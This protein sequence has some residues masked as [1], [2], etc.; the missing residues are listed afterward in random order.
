MEPMCQQFGW[1]CHESRVNFT[2]YR[3]EQSWISLWFARNIRLTCMGSKRLFECISKWV[4]PSCISHVQ[5]MK[6]DWL[7]RCRRKSSARVN[8]EPS[9]SLSSSGRALYKETGHFL[10]PCSWGSAHF[11]P[12]WPFLTT[13][14]FCN[15]S[16]PSAPGV[17]GKKGGF[18]WA[19]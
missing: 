8:G 9:T 16:N 4:T 2:L 11:S 7:T 3:S 6:S 17:W 5:T 12:I 19:G 18:H 10:L 13:T 15:N 1:N 14:L